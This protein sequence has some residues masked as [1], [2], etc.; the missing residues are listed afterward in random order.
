MEPPI[1]K[2]VV[3]AGC[4]DTQ[5][6]IWSISRDLVFAKLDEDGSLY[7]ENEFEIS[8]NDG[9][10]KILYGSHFEKSDVDHNNINLKSKSRGIPFTIQYGHKWLLLRMPKFNMSD[11][12]YHKSSSRIC[13]YYKL[14]QEK[15]M[16][17]SEEHKCFMDLMVAIR[18]VILNKLP[19]KSSVATVRSKL[20]TICINGLTTIFVS[21]YTI[22]L[23]K[24][25]EYLTVDCDILIF[26]IQYKYKNSGFKIHQLKLHS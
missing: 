13:E 24:L 10:G 9:K 6:I 26:P 12:V 25:P 18:D 23:N 2:K 1:W 11:F 5:C 17:R 3:T 20:P 8:I 4:S 21:D 22:R 14:D 19:D 7:T 15:F 16:A